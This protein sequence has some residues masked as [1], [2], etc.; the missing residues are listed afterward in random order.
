MLGEIRDV[1]CVDSTVLR[2]HDTL[3]GCWAACRTNHTLAAV[4]LHMNLERQKPIGGLVIAIALT[5]V[6]GGAIGAAPLKLE[7]EDQ[8][9]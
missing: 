9:P 6:G 4:K 8:R 2:L 5:L 3:A 7:K 1:L